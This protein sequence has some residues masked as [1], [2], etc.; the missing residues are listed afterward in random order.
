MRELFVNVL[1][2]SLSGSIVI[3]V[4]QLLRLVMRKVPKKYICLLWLLAG[5]RLLMPFSIE[6]SFSL[7]PSIE[8]LTESQ[9]AEIENYGHILTSDEPVEAPV[10][11]TPEEVA[12][13]NETQPPLRSDIAVEVFYTPNWFALLPYLWIAGSGAMMLYAAVSYLWLRRRVK[14]SIILSEGIWVSGK[15]DSAFVLGFFRPQVYLSAGLT[16]AE[17]KLVL[18]HERCHIRRGDHLWKLLGFWALA[19]HWFNPLVWL[20]YVL[21]CRDMEMACDEAVVKE[22]DAAQRKAYSAALLSCGTRGRSIAACPVAFGEVSVKQRIKHVLNYRKTGF[23]IVS[24]AVIAVVVVAV[25]FLTTPAGESPLTLWEIQ[26][27]EDAAVCSIIGIYC[28]GTYAEVQ[29]VAE[30]LDAVQI[31]PEQEMDAPMEE[32]WIELEG[33]T[34]V[35]T[36]CFAE[37]FSLVWGRLGE[38]NTAVYSVK[39]PEIMENL[40]DSVY[41]GV[42]WLHPSAEPFATMDEPVAWVQGISMDAVEKA[43]VA[44]N[45]SSKN[46]GSAKN[47]VISTERFEELLPI[48]NDL[49]EEA[50]SAQEILEDKY[51]NEILVWRYQTV[52]AVQIVDG[53]NRLSAVILISPEDKLELFL[54]DD[55]QWLDK[56]QRNMADVCCWTIEDDALLAYMRQ[57]REEP[58]YIMYSD[59]YT[60]QMDVAYST[61]E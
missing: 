59:P 45:W 30:A 50:F 35:D 23:W 21:L 25:C 34:D 20:G 48:L 56:H 44:I 7:Q 40:R 9:W 47:G 46:Y 57:L 16:E 49:T 4:I 36:V 14:D 37:D 17:R 31:G 26:E 60:E 28:P 38:E 52:C 61:V 54:V 1:N 32:F 19:V 5:L 8:P 3:V 39:N 2:V 29:E 51:N 22:M 41:D 27:V 24:I 15:L 13:M 58:S 11:L 12:A 42:K 18:E 33:N 6:S 10:P 55:T 53:A 43:G